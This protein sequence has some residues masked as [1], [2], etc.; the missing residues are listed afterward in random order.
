[1]NRFSSRAFALALAAA[2]F[3]APAQ[4]R[5]ADG[6]SGWE[7]VCRSGRV[8]VETRA[9]EGR[10]VKEIRASGIVDAP[11]W[12]LKN[13]IDDIDGYT[14]LIPFTTVAKVVDSDDGK[15]VSFQRLEM[16][17]TQAR[18]Y[19]VTMNDASYV[20][21]DGRPVYRSEWTTAAQR[22][23]HYVSAAAV[24]LT[25]NDGSWTFEQLADG[26]TLA[27]FHIFVDPE[28]DLPKALVNIAQRMTVAQYID[29]LEQRSALAKYRA[30]RP[31]V[32]LASR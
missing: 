16:P 8:L 13:V 3:A 17:F 15:K 6:A 21:D 9:H 10:K 24:R 11:A 29:N 23:Q 7:E 30:A 28:G 19:V 4:A 32:V 27:T 20:T 1:M 25:L 26:R 2:L 31:S 5:A 12:V 14:Q 22:Y 18:E